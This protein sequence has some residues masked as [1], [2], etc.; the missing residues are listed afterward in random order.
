[1]PTTHPT[2][3]SVLSAVAGTAAGIV[4]GAG[5]VIAIGTDQGVLWAVLPLALLLAAYAPR[6]ISF[7]VGQAGFT[8]FVV[9]LFNLLAPVG[10]RVGL[11]R[12]ALRTLPAAALMRRFVNTSVSARQPR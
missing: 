4:I 10:W 11:V 6:A 8:V 2:G 9:V 12:A 7:A 5:L 3:R 1:M